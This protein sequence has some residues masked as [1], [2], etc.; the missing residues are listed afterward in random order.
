[1]ERWDQR[2]NP[3][4]AER[5]TPILLR[6][7]GTVSGHWGGQR[8]LVRSAQAAALALPAVAMASAIDWGDMLSPNGNIHPRWKAPVGARLAQGMAA[9]AYGYP[10]AYKA[11]IIVSAASVPRASAGAGA[12][13]QGFD[14]NIT[15]DM[16][17]TLVPPVERM[18]PIA[19]V[20]PAAV[21]NGCEPSALGYG[22]TQCA[23]F[24]VDGRNATSVTTA[25]GRA[26]SNSLLV[27]VSGGSAVA[28]TTVSYLQ[29]NWPVALVWSHAG[30]LPA[31]PFAPFQ[32]APTAAEYTT[33][34]GS[35][36]RTLTLYP[37]A[38]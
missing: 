12:G 24:A 13:A 36:T 11:P 30:G 22:S 37:E 26:V 34:S 3:G 23:S 27:H 31:S 35:T 16:A 19:G 8:A 10:A 1:M 21:T 18:P 17:V 15:F 14:V 7:A 29:A 32:V 5:P 28:P 20:V 38:N 9:L 6:A 4:A 33:G 25:N 2:F